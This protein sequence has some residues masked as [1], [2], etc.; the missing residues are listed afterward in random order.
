MLETMTMKSSDKRFTLTRLDTRRIEACKQDLRLFLVERNE[1]TRLPYLLK[2]YRNL[3]VGSFF[4]VDDKSGDGSREYLLKQEDCFVFE[5]SNSFKES[6]AG[7]DWQNCLLDEYGTGHWTIVAD[8]DELLVYPHMERMSLPEL[9]HYLDNERSIA[10]FAFLLDMYPRGDL[11]S[12][13]CMPEKPFFEICPYFDSEYVF[14]EISARASQINEL[15]RVR[16]VG[17]PR[18]RKFYPRQRN[19]GFTNRLLNTV[20]IKMSER[21][22]FL[23]TDR[24]HYAPALIKMPLVRWSKGIRR[25]SS[26]VILA[27]E[28]SRVSSVTGAIMHFKFF[29]DF[30]EK[31]KNEVARGAHF[32]G[33]LEYK[34]YLRHTRKNPTMTLHYQGSRRYESSDSLLAAG[35]IRSTDKLESY[36]GIK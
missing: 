1:I 36:L 9:C 26:H 11:S 16:V 22:T 32:G 6:R 28:G 24:P 25:L 35:L 2:Y 14:R 13:V 30:H 7:V 17:G 31:A 3:G 27:P 33:S 4:V 19:V 5:P 23:K 29:A 34:R 20:V 12:G 21:L 18:I 15:P 10:L 8:A